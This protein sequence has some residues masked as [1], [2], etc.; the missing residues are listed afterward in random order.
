MNRTDAISGL[1]LAALGVTAATMAWGFGLGTLSQPGAGFFPF[2]A[3]IL[4]TGC[5]AGIL[6]QAFLGARAAGAA[7]AD[8]KL[9]AARW[10]KILVCV[11][12]LAAFA[13]ALP[14]IGFVPSTFLVML[15]LSRMDRETSWLA[16]FL[17]ALLGAAGFWILFV[18]LIPVRFPP[19][20]WG[21]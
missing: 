17:I 16:S 15:A 19:A 11:A 14:W 5:A 7:A 18:K 4:V 13:I 9:P 2:W 3:A 8:T 12:I 1:L 10:L 6:L 20:P 21:F